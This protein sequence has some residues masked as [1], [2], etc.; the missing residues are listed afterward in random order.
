MPPWP[1]VRPL[2][3]T[4]RR[5]GQHEQDRRNVDVVVTSVC[6][7]ARPLRRTRG[8]LPPGGF[9]PLPHMLTGSA[10]WTALSPYAVKLFIDL[11]AQY[12]GG[13]NGSLCAAWSVMGPRGWRSKATL[14]KAVEE[15]EAARFILRTRQGGKNSSNLFALTP[16][17]LDSRPTHDVLASDYR[18]GAWAMTPPLQSEARKPS[19]KARPPACR[20]QRRV[21]LESEISEAARVADGKSTEVPARWANDCADP[22]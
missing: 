13:N 19:A 1:A 2:C 6:M 20:T 21:P 10:Q 9:F 4:W 12:R 16:F 17:A 14:Q 5:G 22:Q 3:R 11:G 8:K 18:H 7:S 15:L